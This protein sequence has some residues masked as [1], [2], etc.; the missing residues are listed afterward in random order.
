MSQNIKITVK[1]S[2]KSSSCSQTDRV[3]TKVDVVI[4]A[5]TLLTIYSSIYWL[6][7]QSFYLS[8]YLPLIRELVLVSG[9]FEF[10][11]VALQEQSVRPW[12]TR[13]TCSSCT[14][15]WSE[16][17]ALHL[18]CHRKT[19]SKTRCSTS[20]RPHR[21]CSSI[22][23]P[24]HRHQHR[25]SRRTC[26]FLAWHRQRRCWRRAARRLWC[27]TCQFPATKLT[28]PDANR[29]RARTR[30]TTRSRAQT[31]SRARWRTRTAERESSLWRSVTVLI[32][33]TVQLFPKPLMTWP[34]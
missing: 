6:I 9:S 26:R 32:T 20:R 16:V 19:R 27:R 29:R 15:T 4:L 21:P 3:I 1:S 23:T 8:M 7:Y 31:S 22:I 12:C 24:R 17:Q 28:F 34:R 18:S 13:L 33:K 11:Y 10:Y 2:F 5:D 14:P 25:H 30:S